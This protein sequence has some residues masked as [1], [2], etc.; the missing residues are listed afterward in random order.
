MKKIVLS[1][2]M[3]MTFILASCGTSVKNVDSISDSSSDTIHAD[4][5]QAESI[6]LTM[7]MTGDSSGIEQ[8]IRE[9]NSEDNGYR[10][11][12]KQYS[13][14]ISD[15]EL[16]YEESIKKY[17]YEDI[18]ILQDI[19]NSSEIDIVCDSSFFNES[20]YEIL[21]K[22][23][24]FVD[25]YT[26]MENDSEVNT[27]T[28]DTHI[29]NLNETDGKLYTL[30][31]FYAINTL[32][33][34][35]EYVGNKE[36]WTFDEFVSHWNAM[37]AGSTIMG[38]NQKENVYPIV[39]RNNLDS[40]IDYE[41][42]M[43]HFDSPDFKKILEFCNQFESTNGQKGTYDYDAI[44]FINPILATGIMASPTFNPENGLTCVGYPS[45]SGE[46]AYLSSMDLCYSINAR[47]SSE[48]Q[49]GA[50]MFIRT[51]VTEEYQMDHV[52]PFIEETSNM[53]GYY[54]SE[55]GFCVNKN[56]FDKIAE[57]LINK[58]YYSSSFKEKDNTYERRFPTE[59]DVIELRRY[60][61]SVNQWGTMVDSSLEEIID[62]EVFAYFN[63]EES[64]D[65]CVDII[66]SRA[67]IWIS[68]QS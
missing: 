40:F 47:S 34:D 30:P 60:I 59:K 36:N 57:K 54:S 7:A 58:E 68:E 5:I 10:I 43:V 16:T 23:G 11:E 39:L 22:K 29:L 20:Y 28:L 53:E 64:I 52:I 32:A 48:K 25:L 65:D 14:Q 44:S 6:V 67:S 51:F 31:V 17:Q 4:D 2:S 56:A 66:Q 9:F 38:A 45:Q 62:D 42:A 12:I 26:F 18:G 13:D 61:L 37:P 27:D 3:L 15:E 55:M 24:A 21:Q 41:N 1:I 49:E 8:A 33:G 19:I 35:P 46:G 63:G 50:W